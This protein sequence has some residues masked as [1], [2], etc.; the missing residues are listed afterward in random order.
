MRHDR[1]PSDISRRRVAGI[2]KVRLKS[3]SGLRPFMELFTSMM[4]ELGSALPDGAKMPILLDNLLGSEK[5]RTY[6]E[7]HNLLPEGT[8]P[9]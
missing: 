6:V 7:F 8:S 9:W 3:D 2:D 4:D 5:L 1:R